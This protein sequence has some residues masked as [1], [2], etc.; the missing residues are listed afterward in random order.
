[1]I[2]FGDELSAE[3]SEEVLDALSDSMPE[4]ARKLL[5]F[6]DITKHWTSLKLS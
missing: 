2:E 1:M 6:L 5:P 4:V 3:Q